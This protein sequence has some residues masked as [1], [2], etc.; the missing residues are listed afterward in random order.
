MANTKQRKQRML[1]CLEKHLGIV[2]T[3]AKDAGIDRA[4]HYRWMES[5]SEYKNAVDALEDV[6]LDFAEQCLFDQMR[7][8]TPASTI[9]YLKYRARKRGYVDRKELTGKDGEPLIRHVDPSKLSTE[10]I[11]EILNAQADDDDE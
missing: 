6:A 8:G 4:T 7:D 3:A 11:R 1:E 10:T 2:T 9:F 5:D